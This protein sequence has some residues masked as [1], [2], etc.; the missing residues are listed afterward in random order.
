MRSWQAETELGSDR[1][2]PAVSLSSPTPPPPSSEARRRSETK[3]VRPGLEG[4]QKWGISVS[5]EKT[6]AESRRESRSLSLASSRGDTTEGA[7]E[8][9]RS[10]VL[11]VRDSVLL[12]DLDQ[13]RAFSSCF[14]RLLSTD[15]LLDSPRGVAR[16]VLVAVLLGVMKPGVADCDQSLDPRLEPL[17]LAR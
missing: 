15:P 8:V 13:G 4:K 5:E 17:D 10:V 11:L 9:V 7:Q 16:P 12:W 6:E 2:S 14:S 3:H 1:S